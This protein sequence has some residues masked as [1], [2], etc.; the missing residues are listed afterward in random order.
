MARRR[1]GRAAC[2]CNRS[3]AAAC[4]ARSGADERS[5]QLAA[6]K[7]RPWTEEAAA[8]AAARAARAMRASSLTCVRGGWLGP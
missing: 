6:Q 4:R 2:S 8:A 3:A 7:A 1:C 5:L